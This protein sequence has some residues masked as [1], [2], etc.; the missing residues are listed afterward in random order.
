MYCSHCGGNLSATDKFCPK[1]GRQAKQLSSPSY[2]GRR[3]GKKG[4]YMEE[5]SALTEDERGDLKL[6]PVMKV[7]QILLYLISGLGIIETVVASMQMKSFGLFVIMALAVGV[8]FILPTFTSTRLERDGRIKDAKILILTTFLGFGF[9]IALVKLLSDA[10][11][12]SPEQKG[13]AM[14]YCSK[15]SH[16]SPTK[17]GTCPNCGAFLM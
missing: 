10:S 9:I 2:Q 7:G 8:G 5:K 17:F 4:K 12:L 1:C 16:S 15:C 6:S 11:S 13:S 3:R 14:Y